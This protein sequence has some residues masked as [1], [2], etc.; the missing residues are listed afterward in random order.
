M[1]TMKGKRD[2]NSYHAPDRASKVKALARRLDAH[3]LGAWVDGSGMSATV[4]YA[5]SI[6]PSAK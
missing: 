2:T 4:I 6:S 1:R 5:P 3:D